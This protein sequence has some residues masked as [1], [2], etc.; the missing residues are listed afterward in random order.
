MPVALPRLLPSGRV[1]LVGFALLAAAVAAYVGARETD[2]FAVQE[3]E[4]EGAPPRVARRAEQALAG[5]LVGR[6]LLQVDTADLERALAGLPDVK[7]VSYDRAYPQTLR[8]RL[9]AERPVAVLRRGADAWLVSERGRVLGTLGERRPAKLPRIWVAQLAA[10]RE[11]VV[12]E[13]DEARRPALALGAVLA[14]E[15]AFLSRIRDARLQGEEIT[16]VLRNG[17]YLR[18]GP[19]HDIGLKIAVAKQVLSVSGPI[20]DGYLDVS[21][22][23]RPVARL[24][25]K[26]SD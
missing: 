8:V 25:P 26:V 18:L 6:S 13:L 17:A 21:V 5:P 19:P 22:P 12:L 11:G 3:I 9:L 10:P 14:T 4:V 24:E 7:P 20:G 1:L 16:L 15:S 2:V 23:Q